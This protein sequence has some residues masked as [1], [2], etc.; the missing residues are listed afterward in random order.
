MKS[1][2]IAPLALAVT[3][4]A[5]GGDDG[6]QGPDDTGDPPVVGCTDGT[7]EGSLTRVCYPAEW[8]GDLIIYAHG[9]VAPDEPLAVPENVLGG[10]ASDG[11]PSGA[12][13]RAHR[14]MASLSAH[15]SVGS[16]A[17]PCGPGAAFQGGMLR[18]STMRATWSACS[19]VSE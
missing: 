15:E 10:G 9:Y 6:G 13:R 7:A 1:V 14:T 19:A 18:E 8:N 16:P 4:W 5:C 3:V 12:P 17:N 11:S 2:R